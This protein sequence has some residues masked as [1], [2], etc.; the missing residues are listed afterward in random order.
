MLRTAQM[1]HG[2][3]PAE[4]SPWP[5][6]DGTRAGYPCL[7]EASLKHDSSLAAGRIVTVLELRHFRL[8]KPH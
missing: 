1:G 8:G 6:F 3:N 4:L 2:D 7:R 5:P